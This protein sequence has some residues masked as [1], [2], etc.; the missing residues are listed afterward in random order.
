MN[1]E[2]STQAF[3]NIDDSSTPEHWVKLMSYFSELSDIKFIRKLIIDWLEKYNPTTILDA[4]CGTG[5]STRHLASLVSKSTSITGLDFSQA[6][7]AHASSMQNPHNIHFQTG[8]LTHLEFSDEMFE[9]LRIERVLHHVEDINA[10]FKEIYRVLKPG[11]AVV[12]SEPDFSMIRLFPLP[13]DLNMELGLQLT[14]TIAHGDLGSY[15][16]TLALEHNFVIKERKLI[17][18]IWDDFE[19][20]DASTHFIETLRDVLTYHKKVDLMSEIKQ[21]AKHGG[22]YFAIPIYTLLLE[23][24][25]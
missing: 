5:D 3:S 17:H 10:A 1:S 22:F 4:G 12:V 14:N 25:L 9:A 15:L 24:A 13:N 20:I 6:M 16:H 21:A 19:L 18:I 11:K 7:I 8:N 23:K 2:K